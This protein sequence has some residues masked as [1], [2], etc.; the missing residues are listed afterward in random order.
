MKRGHL[1]IYVG[2]AAGVGKT[3]AMLGEGHRRRERGT[4]IVIGYVETHGR[5]LTEEQ[6]G[7]LEI[8]PRRAITHRGATFE[9]MDIDALLARH[10]E[11]AL[12]DEL[13]HT[14]I[15]GSRN[16]K[17]WQDVEELLD[18]GIDVITTVNIQ[19]LESLNDVV[20]RITGVV[21]RE[22]VPD[23]VVRRAD[24]QELVDMTPYALR[25]RM[26]H[27]NIYPPEKID[28]ALGNYFREGNLGALRELALLWMADR[29][30]E[31]LQDY[32]KDRGIE[33]PWETRERI[34]VGVSG[35][36]EDEALIRRAARMAARAG[37]E[38][39]AVHVIPEDGLAAG[40]SLDATRELVQSQG[41]SFHEVVGRGIPDALLDFARAENVTQVVV[42]ASTQS[43][44]R[45]LTRGSV[46]ARIIRASGAIDVHVISH[47]AE[48]G[49]GGALRSGRPTGLSSSRRLA[50]FPV[51]AVALTLVTLACIPLR[52]RLGLPS[53]LLIYLCVVVGVAALGGIWPAIVTAVLAS[54]L[55]NYYFTP[56]LHT[57]NIDDAANV[58]GIIV[59]I[60]VG[61]LVSVLVDRA[62]RLRAEAQRG[63]AEAEA[64]AR[65]AGWLL[66]EED[67]LP[68]LVD[69]LRTTFGL[70]ATSVVRASGTG[71]TVEAS[72][73]ASP[74][75]TPE[76]G[77][78]SIELGPDTMLVLK[79][80]RLPAEARRV[81]SA[82]AAQLTVAV[83]EREFAREAEEAAEQQAVNDLRAAILAAV[84][85]DLRT[86]LSSIKAAVSSLRQDDVAW[87]ERE[88]AE[89]EATIEEETDR[90]SNLVGNLLDMSRIQ[91]GAL[92]LVPS[93]VGLD[94]VVPK[95]LASLSDG[96]RSVEVDVPESLPRVDVDAA[97]LERAVANLVS[98]AC[99]WSPN[100]SPV[101]VLGS[102]VGGR[103]ELRVVDSGPGIPPED[104]D[105]VFEPFQR[106]GDR[107]NGDGVGL[108]LA[109]A[110]G[111]VEAMGGELRI[112][113]TPGGGLTM[114]VGFEAVA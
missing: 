73:G 50:G 98:N 70:A 10:P 12:V 62:A 88:T 14:N 36:P 55:I 7:D 69:H 38:L 60:L 65:L 13:A 8:V 99:T 101:R 114:V 41:G 103:V 83:R 113:D 26:A 17:R 75:T 106:L 48:P 77:D 28:A 51:A 56:P 108:G 16:E 84:S 105:R 11:I 89:F 85:H 94:E 42:G 9:E 93:K 109:V 22:T 27:G 24:Q 100:G 23:E 59:F 44:W 57:W 96:G 49:G 52:D 5:P 66:S 78:E 79:G 87:N 39:V 20:E 97:L 90:L 1:R 40:Q 35:R 15:P 112:D 43:R 76:E 4:D 3:F 25:R 46:I 64:L 33:G 71:W 80:P 53:V 86:P 29:V 61:A 67:P 72:A 21:Q 34:L 31:A 45:H 95:A 74:P 81:L 102:S 18:A 2:Y 91:T 107:S 32:M 92:Q 30:D 54:L 82:F 110:R 68:N 63:R 58:F 37:G 47:D 111:F 19:H 104:R 6:V